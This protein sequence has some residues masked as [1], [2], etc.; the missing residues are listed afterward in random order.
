MKYQLC[1]D[2][3]DYFA[4]LR[5]YHAA[6]GAFCILVYFHHFKG[7]FDASRGE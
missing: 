3:Y 7:K 4:H 1:F 5:E 6:I 2:A